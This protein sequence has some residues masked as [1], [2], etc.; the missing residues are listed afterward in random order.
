[1]ASNKN[2]SA[3]RKQ[4]GS[5]SEAIVQ[6]HLAEMKAFGADKKRGDAA[7][8]NAIELFQ[9]DCMEGVAN[10]A[11]VSRYVDAYC[12]GAS[13]TGNAKSSFQSA[14]SAF[15]D[16]NVIKAWPQFS[17]ALN[18]MHDS[19]DKD[20]KKLV[21]R[22]TTGKDKFAQL[23]RMAKVIRDLKGA[24]PA[25]TDK[26]IVETVAKA[27]KSEA[28]LKDLAKKAIA[29]SVPTLLP[30]KPTKA[31]VDAATEFCKTFGIELPSQLKP[32]KAA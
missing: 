30:A 4:N 10:I 1:M 15:G 9:R 28:E 17:A 14:L 11:M 13:I 29:D 6:K 24:T 23:Y 22:E 3:A 27:T 8:Q 2:G 21:S 26:W 19:K 20:V 12:E 32:K 18:T 31:Q 7:K 25:I 5:N 16:P